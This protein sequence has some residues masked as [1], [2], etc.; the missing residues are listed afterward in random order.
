MV[1]NKNIV[2]NLEFLRQRVRQKRE[3]AEKRLQE[4]RKELKGDFEHKRKGSRKVSIVE[5][6]FNA[7]TDG[8]GARYVSP[9]ALALG[10]TTTQIGLLSSLPTLLG[11]FTQIFSS[12]AMEKFSRKK[13]VILF[14]TLQAIFWLFVLLSGVFFFIF[15]FNSAVSVNFLI[16]AYTLLIAFGAFVSPIWNSWMKDLVDPD[17]SGKY[18]GTRSKVIGF[19]SLLAMLIGG[20]ILDYF[21][22]TKVFIGFFILFAICFLARLISSQLFRKQYEPG[23]ETEKDYHFSLW[24]FIKKMGHNNFGKFVIAI[25]LMNFAISIASPFFAVYMLKDLGFSYITYTII[26]VSSIIGNLIFV[27]FW[28]KFA[29][30]YGNVKTIKITA[31]LTSLVPILWFASYFLFKGNAGLIPFLIFTEVYS[32]MVFAGFSLTTS[33]FIYDAVT[34][35]RMALCTSYF[36][37]INGIAVFLGATLAGLIA[38]RADLIF[39]IS[40]FLVIFLVSGILRLFM[41]IFFVSRFNEVR[42]VEPFKFVNIPGKIRG[43]TPDRLWQYIDI[44]N[45]KAE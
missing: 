39:G 3:D 18:F 22:N 29:D 19:V 44:L 17:K 4:L 33:N 8:A 31:F 40:I 20:F 36:N 1:E 5:G 9:F 25:S 10:A 28:G 12:K 6:S 2:Y 24:Q 21:K 32:G 7:V 14:T 23:L 27:P 35:Q 43:M 38:S 11:N 37:V 13:I 34:R 45:F 16:M 41:A 42:M 26:I 15:K 30:R